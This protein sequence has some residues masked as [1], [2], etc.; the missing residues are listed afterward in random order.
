MDQLIHIRAKIRIASCQAMEQLM[1]HYVQKHGLFLAVFI[2]GVDV[3]S[4]QIDL[5]SM[6]IGRC[7]TFVF[8]RRTYEGYLI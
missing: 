8:H 3:V 5:R 7:V 4:V 6:G 2:T 1:R